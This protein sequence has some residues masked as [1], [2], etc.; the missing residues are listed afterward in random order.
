MKRILLSSL[1]AGSLFAS[2]ENFIEIG[3]GIVNYK[4]NFSTQSKKNV[5]KLGSSSKE[6]EVFPYVNF[7]YGYD[8]NESLNLY[9]HLEEGLTVGS[10]FNSDYGVFDFGVTYESDVEW[11][12]PFLVG[13]NK[14][15]TDVKELSFYASYELPLSEDFQS[16]ITYQYG[17]KKYDKDLVLKDLKRDGKRHIISIENFLDTD[18][19]AN[20][21]V[22]Y[23]NNLTYEKYDAKS[24]AS[25]YDEYSIGFGSLIPFSEDISLTLLANVGKKQYKA[26][27]KEVNKRVKS[28]IFGVNAIL[29][30]DKPLDYENTFVSLKTGYDK[31]N[32]NADF[33]DKQN[34]YGIV[35]VGYRF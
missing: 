33:Y 15:E 29:H 6:N 8:L 34:T 2:G 11:E 20:D 1:L 14:K 22:V 31:E 5:S 10:S 35:S 9:V 16:R 27:N 25:S 17:K 26:Q 12:N 28:N 19:K 13:S 18:V 23:F 21:A 24:K 4:D 7:Y 32:A 3:A 30:L